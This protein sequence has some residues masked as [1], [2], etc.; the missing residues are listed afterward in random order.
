MYQ[1]MRWMAPYFEKKRLADPKLI[2]RFLLCYGFEGN[3]TNEVAR[4]VEE[5]VLS[6]HFMLWKAQ[7]IVTIGVSAE[8]TSLRIEDPYYSVNYPSFAGCSDGYI[9]HL[10]EDRKKLKL[11]FRRTLSARLSRL[12]SYKSEVILL[13]HN[14]PIPHAM[15]VAF[16]R[17]QR[18]LLLVEQQYV[19]PSF[20]IL[21]TIHH[22][23][24]AII[25]LVRRRYTY[26][27]WTTSTII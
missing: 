22:A 15:A 2:K 11:H 9:Y 26:S 21:R 23:F 19:Y 24:S 1:V 17:R 25:V 5:Y 18:R 13:G 7:Q 20:K 8:F 6:W 27:D 12:E 10:I 4:A 14:K 3:A 16:D